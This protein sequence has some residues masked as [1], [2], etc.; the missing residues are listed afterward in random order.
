[1]TLTQQVREFLSAHNVINLA[2]AGNDGPWASAVF[3]VYSSARFYFLSAPHTRHCQNLAR[4]D[5]VAATI[6]Q[7][8][9][10][11][12]LIKG[13]QLEGRAHRVPEAE[14]EQV[15]QLYSQ[16]FAV[17]GPDA[18]QEIARA[19]DKIHWFELEPA[20]LLFIDNSVSLGHRQEVN[21]RELLDATE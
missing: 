16:R 8:V 2:T 6:Q 18:P 21:I 14:T 12:E 20:R 4:D 17:T 19:L 3:Y 5:R 15:I 10:Q 7:E 1:M 13:V 11:W 9:E